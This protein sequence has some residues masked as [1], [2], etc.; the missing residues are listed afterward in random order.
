VQWSEK[1]QKQLRDATIAFL[2]A[3][4]SNAALNAG[5]RA[6]YVRILEAFRKFVAAN[7]LYWDDR[8]VRPRL[9]FDDWTNAFGEC[10][11]TY[12]P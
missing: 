4:T 10:W 5:D 12:C 6:D 2:N 11:E 9:R 7:D 8:Q 3:R 1:A